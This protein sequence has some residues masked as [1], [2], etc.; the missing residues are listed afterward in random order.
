[1]KKIIITICS[2]VFVV[3]FCWGCRCEQQKIEDEPIGLK[4]SINL[5]TTPVDLE[6]IQ[7]SKG[8]FADLQGKEA[9]LMVF[10]DDLFEMDLDYI[11]AKW[12]SIEDIQKIIDELLNAKDDPNS[13]AIGCVQGRVGLFVKITPG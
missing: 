4:G 6:T 9:V 12:D 8:S 11:V 1:M 13:G 3:I 5:E 10:T 7:W 2:V